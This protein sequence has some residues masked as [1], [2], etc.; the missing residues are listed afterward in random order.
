MDVF[1]GRHARYPSGDIQ[2]TGW[3]VATE[4]AFRRYPDG[5]PAYARQQPLFGCLRSG[6]LCTYKRRRL[7]WLAVKISR[8]TRFISDDASAPTIP[9]CGYIATTCSRDVL[10]SVR[11]TLL[12][13]SS[14]SGD[15]SPA[16]NSSLQE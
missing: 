13:G 12:T 6:R 2:A 14:A 1:P 3:K 10:T 8:H 11:L 9:T 16:R 5:T 15:N 7:C 4:T